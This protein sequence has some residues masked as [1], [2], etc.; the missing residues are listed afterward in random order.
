[1]ASGFGMWY[2]YYSCVAVHGTL[3]ELTKTPIAVELS[4]G[5]LDRQA[6]V[7]WDDTCFCLSVWWDCGFSDGSTLLPWAWCYDRGYRQCCW[8]LNLHLDSLQCPHQ[9]QSR[10]RRRINQGHTS[11][12][13]CMVIFAL[14]LSEDR[15]SKSQRRID[16]ME[17]LANISEQTKEFLKLD[18]EI[19]KRCMKFKDLKSLLLLGR[20]N[21][22]ATALEG[23][24]QSPT[25]SFPER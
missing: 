4:S 6:P 11:Q 9:R 16:I 5:F 14:A 15:S 18:L 17:G 8:I 13:D 10:D 25:K 7:F 23:E 3:E 1:V 20:G 22:H 24:F 12:I 21:Q 19:K 2:S